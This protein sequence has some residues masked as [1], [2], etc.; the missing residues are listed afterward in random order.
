[1][2]S[3]CGYVTE[4]TGADDPAHNGGVEVWNGTFAIAVSAVVLGY[5]VGNILLDSAGAH[6]V[7]IQ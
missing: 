6:D 3:A 1:M 2:M 7:P 5:V 4:P